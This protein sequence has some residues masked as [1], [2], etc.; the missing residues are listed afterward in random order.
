MLSI[1][2]EAR[3]EEKKEK[4]LKAASIEASRLDLNLLKLQ[5]GIV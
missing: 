2:L 5:E 4:I 1:R 3:L